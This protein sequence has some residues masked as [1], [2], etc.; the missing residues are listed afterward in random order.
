MSVRKPRRFGTQLLESMV[1][2]VA[3]EKDSLKPA[4]IKSAR[5]PRSRRPPKAFIPEG[6]E[7]YLADHVQAISVSGHRR[8]VVHINK[9]LVRANTPSEAYRRAMELGRRGTMSYRN[10]A[11]ER[12]KFQFMGLRDLG[13]IHEPLEDGAELQYFRR[14]VYS[15]KKAKALVRPKQ[16][17]GVFAPRVPVEGPDH[18]NGELR[19][20]M[21]ALFPAELKPIPRKKR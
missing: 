2:V 12:V 7:W 1:E 9:V 6:A 13:V 10:A 15:L 14:Y 20:T 8:V 18:V 16:K 17:L 21:E 3:I 4:R 5:R 19:R 11:D